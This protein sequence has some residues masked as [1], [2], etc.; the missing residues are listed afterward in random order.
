MKKEISKFVFE[1][2]EM[3]PAETRRKTKEEQTLAGWQPAVRRSLLEDLFNLV[4]GESGDVARAHF[5]EGLFG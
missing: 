1:I 2:E 3:F 4:P 5:G